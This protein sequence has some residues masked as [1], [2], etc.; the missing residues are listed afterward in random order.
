[1]R[2]D[3]E[4]RTAILAARLEVRT[5]QMLDS[6]ER[7]RDGYLV[8]LLDVPT[9]TD[10]LLRQLS[11]LGRALKGALH[12]VAEYSATVSRNRDGWNDDRSRAGSEVSLP[13]G[14]IAGDASHDVRGKGG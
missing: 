1:M 8:E 13:P 10:Y 3:T 2:Y 4:S 5:L 9:D 12:E 11:H 7:F 14:R 6:L